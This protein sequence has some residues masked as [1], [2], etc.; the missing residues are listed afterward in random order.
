MFTA[1]DYDDVL[2]QI[3][4]FFKRSAPPHPVTG[5]AI[6]D[7][8]T[9]SSTPH[10]NTT[11]SSTPN[12]NT[13]NLSL[14]A[15][16]KPLSALAE[17]I[18][19]YLDHAVRTAHPAYFNQLWGGFTPAC[20]IADIITSAANTSMYTREV[21]PM[22][23]SIEK[24]LVSKLGKLVGFS[25]PG[26]QFT[27][28]GSNG[29]LMAM[30]IARHQ[31]MPQI[32][33][34]GFTHQPPLIA[35]VS[36]DA[37]YSFLKAAQLLGIGAQNLWKV[38]VDEYGQ[39]ETSELKRLIKRARTQG[40]TPFFVAGTAGTTVRGAYDPLE[41][42]G[43]IAQ[44]ERLWFH[45]DGAWGG[46]AA[47]SLK[48]RAMMQGIDKADSVVWD[49]HKM[50]GMTLMCSVLLTKEQGVM[51]GAFSAEGTGYLFHED[52]PETKNLEASESNLLESNPS[53]SNLA[54]SNLSDLGP[55]TLHCGRKA[56]AVKLW[57]TWQ[58]LGDEGWRDLTDRYFSLA[59]RAEMIIISNASL[60][61]V[62]PRQSLNLCF[63]YVPDSADA[64]NERCKNALTIEIR[65]RL[66]HK[67]LA[68][69]NYAAL[70]G[71]V[72][73]RLVVCNN[74]T[75]IA[76]IEK[77]LEDVV[78]I[79][80]EIEKEGYATLVGKACSQPVK[81]AQADDKKMGKPPC[82]EEAI[83]SLEN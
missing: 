9:H 20:F 1:A 2:H 39:M 68:M 14:P 42:I 16:G 17:D 60:E 32:K 49:A 5:A 21:A 29:N 69:V 72:F 35:F 64:N 71:K 51:H 44:Q 77:F 7:D 56:D 65:Q 50:M 30:A 36:Q 80:R 75:R 82:N 46:G 25:N 6:D 24:T 26:G 28:G 52:E 12:S 47:L 43:A 41:D 45:V 37:H 23:T 63:R 66:M 19:T 22:A 40:A 8:T 70:T 4:T 3:E 58:H 15:K 59:E 74:Q 78:D 34:T 11:H 31:S 76:D 18:T 67:G 53:E 81:K 33:Q 55:S 79:G 27:T 57:L 10:S 38:P 61:L 83:Q 73:L 54:E 48:H 62:F 13:L